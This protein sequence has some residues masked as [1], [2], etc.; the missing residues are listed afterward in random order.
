MTVVLAALRG[1]QIEVLNF[2]ISKAPIGQEIEAAHQSI[3]PS[4]LSIEYALY[5]LILKR[6]NE[7]GY[8]DL[9]I[10]NRSTRATV[11]HRYNEDKLH[12]LTKDQHRILSYLTTT[13]TLHET[14]TVPEVDLATA[15]NFN[16]THALRLALRKL[17]EFNAL[18]CSF[19][20]ANAVFELL[21]RPEEF[22]AVGVTAKQENAKK[23]K[24]NADLLYLSAKVE[25]LTLKLFQLQISPIGAYLYRQR[26]AA[27]WT[28]ATLNPPTREDSI[29]LEFLPLFD[30]SAFSPEKDN[31]WVHV[32]TKGEYEVIGEVQIEETNETGYVY[33]SIEHGTIWVRPKT[34]FL[35]GRF[36]RKEDYI[37][38]QSA[39]NETLDY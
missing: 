29:N 25:E 37:K 5:R 18:E 33:R 35:D 24:G 31:L 36:M 39:H 7:L 17:A 8:I 28:D 9:Q 34:K 23:K 38:M 11:L 19:K 10:S 16:N 27:N 4:E 21:K 1:R 30:H 22:V 6:L 32:K 14:I 20:H 15:L 13:Y 12:V 3:N 2:L 26:F